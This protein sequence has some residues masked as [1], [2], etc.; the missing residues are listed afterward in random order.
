MMV[1]NPTAA[2]DSANGCDRKNVR[3]LKFVVNRNQ[4]K[5]TP[6]QVFLDSLEVVSVLSMIGYIE[7]LFLYNYR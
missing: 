7:V 2:I 4:Q 6:D 5:G 1:K 3:L